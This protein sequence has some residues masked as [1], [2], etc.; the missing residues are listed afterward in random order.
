VPPYV[1]S[2]ESDGP[3][4]AQDESAPPLLLPPNFKYVIAV[5]DALEE[6]SLI[7]MHS[8]D[9]YTALEAHQKPLTT[10]SHTLEKGL[11]LVK[12]NDNLDLLLV[13]PTLPEL[14]QQLG[15][16]TGS[17]Q[18]DFNSQVN[19][20]HAD[21]LHKVQTD[22][23]LAKMTYERHLQHYGGSPLHRV[24]LLPPL[25]TT[26]TFSSSLSQQELEVQSR[27]E[28]FL[29]EQNGA[30]SQR[31][32]QTD[33]AY[34]LQAEGVHP[35]VEHCISA[36]GLGVSTTSGKAKPEADVLITRLRDG[37]RPIFL[38]NQSDKEVW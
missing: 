20:L 2:E 16:L 4:W 30:K 34:T 36:T 15:S 22:W 27:L 10:M 37:K 25:N 18:D 31:R 1:P 26:D 9:S 12:P 19:S 13:P 24:V 8:L 6:V 23:I 35:V 5:E 17:L 33:A 21:P 7:G 38:P 3:V 29:A 14:S 32:N 28:D 11:N